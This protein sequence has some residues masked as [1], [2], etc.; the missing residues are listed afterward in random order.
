MSR[1]TITIGRGRGN[2]GRM[3]SILALALYGAKR[4]DR[5]AP[6]PGSTVPRKSGQVA[7]QGQQEKDRR[8]RQRLQLEAKRA[9]SAG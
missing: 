4:T 5:T 2:W 9:G 3:A 8:V 6:A 7:H 1:N